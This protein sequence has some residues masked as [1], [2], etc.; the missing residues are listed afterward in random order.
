[1]E[2]GREGV[3]E[4]ERDMGTTTDSLSCVCVCVCVCIFSKRTHVGTHPALPG[5]PHAEHKSERRSLRDRETE[6][7]R[8]RDRG[9]DT[10]RFLAAPAAGHKEERALKYK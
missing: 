2:G 1:M 5:A 9:R 7:S 8:D 6:R 3:A 10:L 4:T